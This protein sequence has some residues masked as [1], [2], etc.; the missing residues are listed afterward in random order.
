MYFL[1][2]TCLFVWRYLTKQEFGIFIL[3]CHKDDLALATLGCL[4]L[5]ILLDIVQSRWYKGFWSSLGISCVVLFFHALL[6]R[7]EE[8][9]DKTADDGTILHRPLLEGSKEKLSEQS[10]PFFGCGSERPYSLPPPFQDRLLKNLAQFSY[11]YA[12][13]TILLFLATIL[14]CAIEHFLVLAAISLIWM[15]I[16]WHT[17]RSVQMSAFGTY[18]YIRKTFLFYIKKKWIVS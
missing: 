11:P 4:T 8:K 9:G 17:K 15:I 2:L 16:I 6:R 3:P 14:I 18:K 1:F 7:N 12:V 5:P 13:L 10:Y